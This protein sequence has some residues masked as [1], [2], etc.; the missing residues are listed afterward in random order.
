M[1]QSEGTFLRFKC[2]ADEGYERYSRI[3]IDD[4]K[5]MKGLTMKKLF[6]MTVLTLA[7]A[8]PALA[9][10]KHHGGDKHHKGG[11][12]NTLDLDN[13]GEITRE[14]FQAFH[15]T[16]FTEM[17]TDNSGTV[18]REEAEAAKAKW[19]EKMQE[20]RAEHK[21]MKGDAAE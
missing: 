16:K 17:D 3:M 15:A 11:M 4:R 13:N 21:R 2:S 9:G 19:K 5:N 18:T 1:E 7:L 6:A 12:F 10:D 20:R 14:E 8:S